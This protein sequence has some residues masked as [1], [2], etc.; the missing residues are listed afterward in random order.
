VSDRIKQTIAMLEGLSF[1][2]LKQKAKNHFGVTLNRDDTK[3]DIVNKIVGMLSKNE[4]ARVG[5]GEVQPGWARIK[6]HSV[7]GVPDFPRYIDHNGY[8]AWLPVGIEIDVPIKITQPGGVLRC[9]QEFGVGEDDL[10]NKVTKFQD[11]IP[12]SI[13]EINPGPDPRPGREVHVSHKR[14]DKMDYKDRYGYWPS[15]EEVK[16]WKDARINS[17]LKKNGLGSEE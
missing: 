15:D 7:N 13:L 1:P 3:A 6:L 2:E 12:F 11:S 14:R 9:S 17:D 16:V 8:F 4:F 5:E 10:G